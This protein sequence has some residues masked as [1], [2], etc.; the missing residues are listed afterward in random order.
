MAVTELSIHTRQSV[1]GGRA[2]GES[3]PYE[4][5]A[6]IARF[7]ADPRHPAH[8]PIADPD[9]APRDAGGRVTAWADFYLLRPLESV[10]GRGRLLLDVPNRGRKVALGLF[11]SALRVPDPTT[12]EDFGTGFLMREGYT[13]AWVGWQH[14]VPRVDGAMALAVPRAGGNGQPISGLMR[15]EFRPNLATD[16]LP[17]A[18]R[19]HIP[20]PA[21]DPDD[22]EAWLTVRDCAGAPERAVARSAWPRGGRG[23]LTMASGIPMRGAA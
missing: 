17:L 19:S 14:D 4:K 2:F 15:C 13:V 7:A 8:E 22:P 10:R 9:R 1:L 6:G 21:A 5:I 20:Q 3:G 16:V 23:G 11:N 12:P 18:D